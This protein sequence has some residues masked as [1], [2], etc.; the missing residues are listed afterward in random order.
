M[1]LI[2]SYVSLAQIVETILN[3]NKVALGLQSIYFGD[4]E[5]IPYTPCACVEPGGKER[6]L[7]GMPRRT[8]VT[9]TCY[10]IVYLYNLASPEDVREDAD[11]KAEQIEAVLHADAQLRDASLEPRVIDSMVTSVDS[12]YQ[13]KRNSLYRA[14]RLTFEARSQVLLPSNAL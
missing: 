10:I 6:R 11:G 2:D 9:L 13:P 7:T 1:A 14:S 3:T 8:E 5:R 12:G 4:Q